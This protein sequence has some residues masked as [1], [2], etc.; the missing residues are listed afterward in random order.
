MIRPSKLRIYIGF[1]TVGIDLIPKE[2]FDLKANMV[3]I[4]SQDT[5]M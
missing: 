2:I 1:C 4:F 3:L 5:I